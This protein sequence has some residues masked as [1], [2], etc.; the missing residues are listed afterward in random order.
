M[1]Y[2]VPDFDKFDST[3]ESEQKPK[4]FCKDCKDNAWC[5]YGPW[6]DGC[7]EGETNDG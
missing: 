7:D 1:P 5:S 3:K 2:T 4:C 6:V